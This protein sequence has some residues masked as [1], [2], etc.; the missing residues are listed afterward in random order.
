[1]KLARILTLIVFCSGFLFAQEEAANQLTPDQLVKVQ[2]IIFQVQR[3]NARIE[4]MTA[5]I[6]GMRLQNNTLATRFQEEASMVLTEKNLNPVEW[7]LNPNTFQ[8]EER[9]ETVV[10][11]PVREA[12][13]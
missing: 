4:L 6:A 1:M 9:T 5:Q 12:D 3:N 11:T 13:P 7:Q 2:N 10:T 8:I